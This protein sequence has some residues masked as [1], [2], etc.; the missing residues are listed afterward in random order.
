MGSLGW[1]ELLIMFVVFA[2]GTALIV[3][4]VYLIARRPGRTETRAPRFCN[5]C[6]AANSSQQRFC[7][8]CGERLPDLTRYESGQMARW[9]A[10][11]RAPTNELVTNRLEG[12][13]S[14]VER[15]TDLLEG[16]PETPSR[17]KSDA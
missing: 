2:G 16:A 10:V 12:P 13:P 7:G 8:S 1:P 14:I 4:L 6:G 3:T 9:D 11:D 17:L 5:K 15:T